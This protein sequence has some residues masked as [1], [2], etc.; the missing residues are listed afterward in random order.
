[1]PDQQLAGRFKWER[2]FPPQNPSETES[3]DKRP[4]THD[5]KGSRSFIPKQKSARVIS[6]SWALTTAIAK[7]IK[8]T[9]MKSVAFV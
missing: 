8:N 1:V 2:F 5:A 4:V 6:I 9:P 7:K 3:A